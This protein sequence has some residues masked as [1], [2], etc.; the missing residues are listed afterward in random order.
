[1][2]RLKRSPAASPARGTRS[3]SSGERRKHLP[4]GEIEERQRSFASR[5]AESTGDHTIDDDGEE[6]APGPAKSRWRA[7]IV[8]A[9]A[10]GGAAIAL[11]VAY[12]QV[13][14]QRREQEAAK[15]IEG[16]G[17][18][19][20]RDAGGSHVGSVSTLQ[21]R[22]KLAEALRLLPALRHVTALDASRTSIADADLE[23]IT[24]LTQL[25]SLALNVTGV[26]D[27][28]L[29]HL[30]DLP[31]LQALHLASTEV[32][33]KGLAALVGL[34][35]LRILDLFGTNVAADLAPL[36]ELEQ[37][38]HLVLRDVK[39]RGDVLSQLGAL[40]N[41][42]RLSLE[43][44]TYADEQIERLLKQIPGLAIDR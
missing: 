41:L 22:E 4:G 15:Q 42:T 19:V 43:G 10:V 16:L 6:L 24:G 1:M 29:D 27:V 7:P 12:V 11:Y 30:A 36:A 35:E 32:S 37:L 9:A 2:T 23:R 33:D 25:N 20:V 14:G 39:L 28:G 31:R 3:R 18:I 5:F 26:T 17:A 44:S 40:P 38:G 13:A 34:Q 8:I 21:S